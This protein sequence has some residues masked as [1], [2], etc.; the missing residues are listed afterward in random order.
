VVLATKFGMDMQGRERARLGCPCIPPLRAQGGGGQPAAPRNRAHRPL[1]AAPARPG[2]AGRGGTLHALSELVVEAARC[3]TL[4]LLELRGLGGRRRALD[5][6]D[7]RPA[8]VRVR[9]ER[10]LALQPGGR[11]GSWCRRCSARA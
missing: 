6:D 9:P 2:D 3:A 10:V 7:R 8:A 4:G 5:R 1:P 11:G